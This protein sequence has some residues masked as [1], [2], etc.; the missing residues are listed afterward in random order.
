MY[1]LTLAQTRVS[2]TKSENYVDE[3]IWVSR[4]GTQITEAST[5]DCKVFFG[6]MMMMMTTN[7]K[8]YRIRIL[9]LHKYLGALNENI[10]KFT[11]ILALEFRAQRQCPARSL[12]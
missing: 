5:F 4:S 9:L 11:N 7:I 10:V 2:E 12:L 3:D 8:D 6:N 1:I